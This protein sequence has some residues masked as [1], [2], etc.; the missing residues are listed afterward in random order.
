LFDLEGRLLGICSGTGRYEPLAPSHQYRKRLLEGEIVSAPVEDFRAREA[1]AADPGAFAAALDLQDAAQRHVAGVVHVLDGAVEVA[2]GLIVDTDGYVIT[3]QSLVSMTNRL[4]CRM[5]FLNSN[6]K[7]VYDARI[8]ASS[9]KHDLALLKIDA[10]RLPTIPWNTQAESVSLGRIVASLE[11]EPLS[12]AVIGA[13]ASADPLTSEVI[14]QILLKVNAGPHGEAVIGGFPEHRA[15]LDAFRDL[16]KSGDVLVRLN[17]LLTPTPEEYG[18]VS[19]RLIYARRGADG[20]IDYNRP[21]DNS[22]AGDPVILTIRRDGHVLDVRIVKVNPGDRNRLDAY[23]RPVSLRR[24]GF[25][26]VFVHDGRLSPSQCGGPVVS[27]AGEVVGLN[28]AR[29]DDTRTLAIPAGVLKEV[30][31]HLLAQAKTG[32]AN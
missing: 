16:V 22:F 15:D 30:V 23:L 31:D 21:A 14:P 24:Q 27:L 1:K 26:A 8:V 4:K 28:I 6:T 9:A 2:L 32:K 7:M 19:D 5:R 3:K 11:V 13:N 12:F 20:P 10:K 25:P 18:R 17:G 29:T